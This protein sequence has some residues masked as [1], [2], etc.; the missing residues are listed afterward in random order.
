ML[1]SLAFARAGTGSSVTVSGGNFC[2]DYGSGASAAGN[3]VLNN[4]D[5]SACPAGTYAHKLSVT[6]PVSQFE[7]VNSE[8]SVAAGGE[9]T[10]TFTVKL[11]S[12]SHIDATP[13]VKDLTSTAVSASVSSYDSVSGDV[14][15]AYSGGKPAAGDDIQITYTYIP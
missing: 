10:D 1:G 2:V 15:V 13:V 9:T 5:N 3:T 12:G 14:H 8:D 6:L 7:G 11:P 4:W